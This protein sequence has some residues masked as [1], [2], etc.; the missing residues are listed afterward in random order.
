MEMFVYMMSFL[1]VMARFLDFVFAF[2]RQDLAEDFHYTAFRH[3]NFLSKSQAEL[4]KIP[5]LGRSGLE[6]RLSYNLWSVEPSTSP[7]WS[8]R[9]TAV[10]HSF[11]LNYGRALWLNVKANEIMKERIAKATSTFEPMLAR[12]STDPARSFAATLVTHLIFFEWCAENW[13]SYISSLEADMRKI[14]TKVHNA[15]LQDVER[16]LAVDPGALV[17]ALAR[18]SSP[19]SKSH[20]RVQT[21]PKRQTFGSQTTDTGVSTLSN[22]NRV[23]S[24]LTVTSAGSIIDR[25]QSPQLVKE[26]TPFAE[27]DFNTEHDRLFEVLKQFSFDEMQRLNS[28]GSDFHEVRLVMGLNA[29]VLNEITSYYKSLTTAVE[30]PKNVRDNCSEDLSNFFQHVKGIIREL[31]MEQARIDSLMMILEDGKRLVSMLRP[32]VNIETDSFW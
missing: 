4:H 17:N 7:K 16:A 14:L 18:T 27:E 31:Q 20:T 8:I 3:E 30:C 5:R 32:G 10:Y 23:L 9:Q 19:S 25:I 28:I 24:G 2:G 21:L 12:S 1:Q 6:I 11:D 13:R 22:S 15:P 26:K 29:D